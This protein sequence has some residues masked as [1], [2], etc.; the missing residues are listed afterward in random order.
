MDFRVFSSDDGRAVVQSK[1]DDFVASFKHGEWVRDMAFDAYEMS[2]L[3][4][5]EDHHEAQRLV[6]DAKR[7]LQYR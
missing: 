1:T 7:A 5:V 4:Q 3:P 2:E 6:K